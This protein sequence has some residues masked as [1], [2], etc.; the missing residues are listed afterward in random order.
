MEGITIDVERL[1]DVGDT[2]VALWREIARSR[3]SELEIHSDTAMV[4]KVRAG[5]I[6]EARGYMNRDQALE[7]AGVVG[8]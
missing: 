3:H 2:V 7:A 5:R 1:I 6:V 8:S 4:F